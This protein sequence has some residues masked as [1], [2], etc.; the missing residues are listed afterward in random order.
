MTAPASI[1]PIIA[2]FGPLGLP[3]LIILG[4]LL[5]IVVVVVAVIIWAVRGKK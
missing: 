3:E 1:S 2:G 4:T 5:A